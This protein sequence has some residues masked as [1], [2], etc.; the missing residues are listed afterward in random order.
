MRFGV[1]RRVIA[2]TSD[3]IVSGIILLLPH[4]GSGPADLQ[5]FRFKTQALRP[6]HLGQ[7]HSWPALGPMCSCGYF[8]HVNEISVDTSPV[9]RLTSHEVPVFILKLRSLRVQG[10]FVLLIWKL[11]Y[12]M[13]LEGVG[14]KRR[15]PSADWAMKNSPY[16]FRLLLATP[17]QKS[18]L[19]GWIISLLKLL[20]SYFSC[21]HIRK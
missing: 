18:W 14:T 15:P 10:S 4:C 8:H 17:E 19:R 5:I 1:Q 6:K 13:E 21:D 16:I 11:K 3:A 20:T 7:E 12:A 2:F 9:M